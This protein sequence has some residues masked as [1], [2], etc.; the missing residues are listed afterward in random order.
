ML[1][2]YSYTKKVRKIKCVSYDDKVH[3]DSWK[4]VYNFSNNEKDCLA[5]NM[6]V[7]MNRYLS[8]AFLILGTIGVI[9]NVIIVYTSKSSQGDYYGD[10]IR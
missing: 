6:N 7:Q 10:R 2:D 5:N 9:L 4:H 8:L 1:Q 3:L